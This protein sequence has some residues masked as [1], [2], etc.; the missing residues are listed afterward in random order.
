MDFPVSLSNS[1]RFVFAIILEFTSSR[2]IPYNIGMRGRLAI[3]TIPLCVLSIIVLVDGFGSLIWHGVIWKDIVRDLHS[4]WI[5]EACVRDGIDPVASFRGGPAPAQGRPNDPDYP[6]WALTFALIFTT[7][8]WTTTRLL[9]TAWNAAAVFV[10]ARWAYRQGSRFDG[11]VLLAAAVLAVGVNRTVLDVGQYTL[12]VCAL[13]VLSVELQEAGYDSLA[14]AALA[15]SMVKFSLSVPFGLCFLVKGKWK[16]LALAAAIT[17]SAAFASWPFIHVSPWNS[18]REAMSVG[19]VYTTSSPTPLKA[20]IKLGVSP[21]A[22]VVI[23]STVIFLAGA[24]A[25]WRCRAQPWPILLAI[26]AVTARFWTYHL[27]YDDA[28]VMFLLAATGKRAIESGKP[29]PW[30]VFL[31]VG[32]SLWF[33]IGFLFRWPFVITQNVI[34]IC[35]LIWLLRDISRQPQVTD[36]SGPLLPT[37]AAPA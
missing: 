24:A 2:A 20:L 13:L 26:A 35:A 12:L 36:R 17:V 33:S 8:D 11:G 30:M 32:I 19:S 23:V 22:A 1:D 6:P 29:I 18:F 10:L 15:L 25:M 34:W 5:E 9:F 14:G 27:W 37:S 16:T 3:L 7:S 21:G 31:A 28:I 4:R